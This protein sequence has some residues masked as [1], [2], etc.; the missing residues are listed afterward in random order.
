[1]N[2]EQHQLLLMRG[3]IASLP[4]DQQLQIMETAT[5]LREIVTKHKEV[6]TIALALVGAELAA[7]S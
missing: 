5:Q 6:G 7:Q 3:T 2:D 1:M 4:V